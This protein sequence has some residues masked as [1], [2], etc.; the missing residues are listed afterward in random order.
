ML[1]PFPKWVSAT[2]LL[3]LSV[4][5]S[6]DGQIAPYRPPV[7][8]ELIAVC[9][10]N[11]AD[12]LCNGTG[13]LAGKIFG[14]H[15]RT[16]DL[17]SK[18]ASCKRTEDALARSACE[19]TFRRQLNDAMLAKQ[20]AELELA[21]TV[22]DIRARREW[23]AREPSAAEKGPASRSEPL[24]GDITFSRADIGVLTQI[25]NIQSVSKTAA[26]LLLSAPV[27]QM[28]ASPN[29]TEVAV[30]LA[31]TDWADMKRGPSGIGVIAA[32]R[33]VQILEVHMDSALSDDPPE[34][35]ARE[36]FRQLA[37]AND[38]RCSG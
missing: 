10:E 36:Y 5:G 21:N 19:G 17:E 3:W 28:L 25:R 13:A 22:Q 11:R 4:P 30:T 14:L 35:A 16:K 34:G 9:G 7:I 12:T 23:V 31:T 26:A 33:I 2:A 20:A 8:Q 18:V 37:L 38:T 29:P 24:S 6:S 27:I 32:C 1:V 15:I